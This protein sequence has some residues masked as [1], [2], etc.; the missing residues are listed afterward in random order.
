MRLVQEA[1]SAY[2]RGIE[3]LRAQSVDGIEPSE[4][5]MEELQR[6]LEESRHHRFYPTIPQWGGLAA[7][8]VVIVGIILTAN[9]TLD[10]TPIASPE[11]IQAVPF[12]KPVANAGIPFVQF[13]DPRVGV[14]TTVP[15]FY[16]S[17]YVER[18]SAYA[19]ALR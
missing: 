8:L 7:A 17:G 9:R 19:T 10:R 1:R 2:Q 15:T 16:G 6:R 14:V 18:P 4:G 11:P 12:P 3:A 5:F 13:Q